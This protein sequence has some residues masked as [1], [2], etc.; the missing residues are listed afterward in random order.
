MAGAGSI[1]RHHYQ[2][3]R[4]TYVWHTITQSLEPLRIVVVTELEKLAKK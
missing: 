1:Y 4:D 2:D 3:V